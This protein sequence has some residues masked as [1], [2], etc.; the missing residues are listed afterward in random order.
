MSDTNSKTLGDIQSVAT[1]L[2]TFNVRP[3]PLAGE[4]WVGYLVRFTASN[5]LLGFRSVMRHLD[6]PAASDFPQNPQFM[7]NALAVDAGE[8]MATS[9]PLAISKPSKRTPRKKASLEY[10]KYFR[11]CPDCL[12]EDEVPHV[13]A[14][15][16]HPIALTC[17][18]HKTLLLDACKACGKNFDWLQ[19][20]VQN[21]S[22]GNDLLKEASIPA[23]PWATHLEALFKEAAPEGMDHTFAQ[24]TSQDRL[25]AMV[26]A[27]LVKPVDK[28]TGL[29]PRASRDSS[30]LL[31][32]EVAAQTKDWIL[33]WTDVQLN[34]LIDQFRMETD[35]DLKR[36]KSCLGARRFSSMRNL[37]DQAVKRRA[38]RDTECLFGPMSD[39][40]VQTLPVVRWE[41]LALVT[42]MSRLR[43]VAAVKAGL[44]SDVKLVA[45]GARKKQDVRPSYEA[46]V[47]IKAAFEDSM[48]CQEV[49]RYLN[50]SWRN[51]QQLAADGRLSMVEKTRTGGV[52][53]FLKSDVYALARQAP[54]SLQKH[55]DLNKR[56]EPAKL[57]LCIRALKCESTPTPNDQLAPRKNES[58]QA[59]N[60]LAAL[61]SSSS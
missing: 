33:G 12:K 41:H 36:V 22:C 35:V 2:P 9:K 1:K 59:P 42:S 43:I 21:C 56:T 20:S 37:V 16:T 60:P 39:E 45:L 53:R 14:M 18:T 6:L 40:P 49:C 4:A 23:P 55:P 13:R 27:W 46:F 28:V 5:G 10:T 50:L 3:R 48:S 52:Q 26:I 54:S 34:E 61:R 25:A 8:S 30:T 31:N 47:A 29:R 24:S 32:M 51:V 17:K 57:E 58:K 11:V 15:W 38:E 44:F 19:P 7:L